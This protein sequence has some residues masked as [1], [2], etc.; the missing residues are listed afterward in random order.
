MI[1]VK[2][3]I[4][5]IIII[6]IVIIIMIPILPW[7]LLAGA[8][9]LS[10]NPKKP[11]VKSGEFPVELTYRLGDE[12]YTVNDIYVCEYDGIGMNE[13]VGKYRKWKGYIKS[14]GEEGILLT[15]DETRNI[16]VYCYVGNAEYYMNDEKTPTDKDIVPNVCEV[17]KERFVTYHGMSKEELLSRYNIE[18]VSWKLSEPIKNS[19]G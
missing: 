9:V 7:L 3:K 17:V 14:T 11:E 12:T 2:G 10:P 1:V 16:Y 8:M 4:I 5:L 18:I 13:G 6:V 15:K 19:F